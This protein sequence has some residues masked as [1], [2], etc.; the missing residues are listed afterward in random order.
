MKPFVI[1]ILA[2]L[3]TSCASDSNNSQLAP[4]DCPTPTRISGAI[5]GTLSRC[6]AVYHVIG[7]LVVEANSTLEIEPGVRL[8]FVD[9]AG[10]EVRGSLF[11]RGDDTNKIEFDAFETTWSGIFFNNSSGDS[12]MQ[13]CR[14]EDISIAA[15]SARSGAVEVSNSAVTFQ[16]CEFF[17][18][19]SDLGG[20]IF[21][22]GDSLTVKNCIF[23]DNQA[24]TSGGAVLVAR[25]TTAIINNTFFRNTS[26]NHGGGLVLNEPSFS[27]V[28]N[29][30]FFRN[31]GTAADP[32]IT[33]TGDSGVYVQQFNFLASGNMDPL[34]VT[35]DEV[36]LD[37]FSPAIDAGNPAV[38]FNDADGS[39]ND[40]GAFGGPNGDW[41]Q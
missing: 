17:D 19:H 7:T 36:R 2:S 38:E 29:N 9:G 8:L 23:I 35:Q 20:A 39:R 27:N 26:I 14:I 12:E 25:S 37:Q 11:A 33:V 28:Q 34:F 24:V 18:N 15:G 41:T 31:I 10:F 4:P 16:N 5:S 1:A 21:A 3:L 32:R 22:V 40:Q 13:F 6:Q 30:I